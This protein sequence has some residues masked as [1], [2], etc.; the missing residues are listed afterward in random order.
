MFIHPETQ[1]QQQQ[2]A[3]AAVMPIMKKP[4]PCKF[5]P[6][7]TNPVC[8][9]IHP[10]DQQPAVVYPMYGQQPSSTTGARVPI[11]CKNGE[12]CTRPGC[13]FLH[14]GDANPFAEIMASFYI[15]GVGLLSH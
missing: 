4:F 13:H 10:D 9:F 8:S 5:Y 14:P 12:H 6:Y 7:C 3:A 11:P 2:P 1:Q 15:Q